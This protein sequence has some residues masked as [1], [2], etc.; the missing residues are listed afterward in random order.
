MFYIHAEA[1]VKT[2]RYF[3]VRSLGEV[4]WFLHP[5]GLRGEGREGLHLHLAVGR[6]LKKER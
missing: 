6:K 3:G 1:V 5:G 4:M 2:K